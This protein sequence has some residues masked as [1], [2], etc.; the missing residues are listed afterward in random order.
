LNLNFWS[1][2]HQK[3]EQNRTLLSLQDVYQFNWKGLVGLKNLNM[4]GYKY[5][6]ETAINYILEMGYEAISNQI[7]SRWILK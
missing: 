2:E 3:S 7:A 5:K 6:T 1:L 4:E